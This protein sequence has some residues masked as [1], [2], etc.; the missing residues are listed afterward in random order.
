MDVHARQTEAKSSRFMDAGE[1]LQAPYLSL[2]ADAILLRELSPRL[3]VDEASVAGINTLLET[4]ALPVPRGAGASSPV[5]RRIK[6]SRQDVFEALDL[7]HPENK[8][9]PPTRKAKQNYNG[10]Y[11]SPMH[12]L[13]NSRL[14]RFVGAPVAST[15][16]GHSDFVTADISLAG[17]DAMEP[18]LQQLGVSFEETPALLLRNPETTPQDMQ[19]LQDA[20]RLLALPLRVGDIVRM[21]PDISP[22]RHELLVQIAARHGDLRSYI[23]EVH[24]SRREG[25]LRGRLLADVVESTYHPHEPYLLSVIENDELSIGATNSLLWSLRENA[26]LR[27]TKLL[28]ALDTE[29]ISRLGRQIVSIYFGRVPLSETEA[30]RYPHLVPFA[31]APQPKQ[32]TV[33]ERL[34]EERLTGE[35]QPWLEELMDRPILP[36]ELPVLLA[37][38]NSAAQQGDL[39]M[40]KRYGDEKLAHIRENRFSFFEL[41]GWMDPGHRMYHAFGKFVLRNTGFMTAPI[42]IVRIGRELAV[43]ARGVK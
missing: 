36:E 30:A 5:A 2:P 23:R 26:A 24:G 37:L 21:R 31:P 33:A 38:L 28:E 42:Q 10:N 11:P 35:D 13:H 12:V 32:L 9:A 34:Y 43:P 14:L 8:L 1:V 29:A 22:K 17:L 15:I 40:L 41:L 20:L 16:A 18:V 6:Q 39:Q 3:V 7:E 4:A 25:P 19:L 27:R